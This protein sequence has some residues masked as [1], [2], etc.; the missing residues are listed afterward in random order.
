[1]KKVIFLLV[2]SMMPTIFED[3][4]R[5]K[6]VP[7]LQFLKDQGRYWP[8]CVTV[9]PT[10]TATVDSSLLTGVFPDVHRIPG[11]V[12]YDP[13][14][15]SIV[16]YVNGPQCIWK[17]GLSKCAKNVLYNLNEKHLS[18]KVSTLFEEL[19]S[20]GKT[21]ASIN[22]IV[23]RGKKRHHVRL[24]FLMN[25][26]TRFGLK[27]DMSGPDVLTLGAMVHT[28]LHRNIPER[29]R[30]MRQKYGINDSYA[31]SAAKSLIESQNQPDFMLVY[32]PDN[33]HEVHKKNP[34]HAEEPLIRVDRHIQN[35]LSSFGSW[36]EA[37]KQCIF[38][39]TSDHGQTRIGKEEG[40]NIDLDKLLESFRGLKLGEG[41]SSHD[42][43]VCNNE[44][45]AYVYPLRQDKE[46][47]I[48]D[49][50]VS[51]S[52][53]DLI[54]WKEKQ[55]VTVKE[56]GSGR[57]I[58]F[59]PN[60]PNKDIYGSTWT[61]TGDWLTLDLWNYDGIVTYGDYPDVL[62]RLYGALYSQDIPMIVITARPRY[63]FKSRFYP[64]HLNG[65]SH[66]SLHKY[67][68]IIPLI[69]TGT[70][71]PIKEPPRLV[72]LKQYILDLF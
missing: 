7:A 10:M 54:A 1:M 68:S 23:H 17:L 32:L 70:E 15:K 33:D 62:S 63:E 40:F 71:H 20:M 8:D 50:L 60:G 3:C 29:L 52:R 47:D 13:E 59:E 11:L 64:L 48:I 69:I 58:Y 36:D 16:N 49:Q 67:D 19:A 65:G 66:G 61:I 37:V 31:V 18:K 44:R 24:P 26:S 43:V 41:V 22:A 12:W 56:G 30:G 53:I 4:M 45:M 57:T 34:A 2:D 14:E 42:L 72:D 39:V 38:I 35:I 5:H 21:S 51:E 28:D 55:G 9:F 25:M 27:D 6:T 46:P